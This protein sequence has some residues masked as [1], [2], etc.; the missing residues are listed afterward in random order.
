MAAT[1]LN[2]GDG[3]PPIGNT[4]QRRRLRVRSVAAEETHRPGG[5]VDMWNREVV[6]DIE[7]IIGCPR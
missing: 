7:E 6:P 1:G 2:T 4:M 5:G 3:H